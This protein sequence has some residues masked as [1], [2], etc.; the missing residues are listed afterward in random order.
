[1][2]TV[3]HIT[4]RSWKYEKSCH[5][6]K[7]ALDKSWSVKLIWAFGLND[8]IFT[9]IS[10]L[11]IIVSLYTWY[12]YESKDY[13]SQSM[14]VSILWPWGNHLNHRWIF[15]T[16]QRK[17]ILLKMTADGYEHLLVASH[18]PFWAWCGVQH[19]NASLALHALA[20]PV[21]GQ[22]VLTG[23]VGAL[24]TSK[25]FTHIWE[26]RIVEAVGA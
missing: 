22:G 9:A 21:L 1:M 8:L 10:W 4:Y 15:F 24:V 18:S 12:F 26:W 3:N 19:E 6:N 7:Q 25:L 14:L 5:T 20:H 13:K 16:H 17:E 2:P 23:G 11:L